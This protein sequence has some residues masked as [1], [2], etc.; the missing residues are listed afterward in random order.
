LRAIGGALSQQDRSDALD[1]SLTI[2]EENVSTMRS[3]IKRMVPI[4]WVS[5]S[6]PSSTLISTDNASLRR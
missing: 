3:R 6:V 2:I 1:E 4:P 5:P